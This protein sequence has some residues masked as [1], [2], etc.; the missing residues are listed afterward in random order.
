MSIKININEKQYKI[1]DRLTVDQYH[2]AIQFDWSDTKYYPMI[3]AQ[4]TG[5][6]IKQLMLADEEAMTLA[7]AFIV[8]AMN[9]RNQCQII[10]L[11]T[12][13]FGQFVDLDVYVTGGLEQNFKAIIDII[14]APLENV[15]FGEIR[16]VVYDILVYNLNI[17]DCVFY[18][19]S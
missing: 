12:M 11:D 3:V 8:K 16:R 19:L 6:P 2:K 9:D 7:I 5:A 15:N 13:T 1:P 14:V 18:I 10:D 17:H 4:L